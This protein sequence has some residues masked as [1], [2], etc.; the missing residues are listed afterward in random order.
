CRGR[1][2]VV[3]SFLK[4][5]TVAAVIAAVAAVAW[6]WQAERLEREDLATSLAYN[7]DLNRA[8]Q[9]RLRRDRGRQLVQSATEQATRG[10]TVN[11]ERLASAALDLGESPEARGLLMAASRVAAPRLL[12]TGPEQERCLWSGT[13]V[14]GRLLCMGKDAMHVMN[15]GGTGEVK[16]IVTEN[17]TAP[18]RHA[19]LSRDGAA[20]VTVADT[21]RLWEV[22]ALKETQT[23]EPPPGDSVERVYVSPKGRWIVASLATGTARGWKTGADTERKRSFPDG[24]R[25][26]SFLDGSTAVL[27]AGNSLFTWD[28]SRDRVRLFATVTN[29]RAVHVSR[30]GKTVA[31]VST[32]ED[33]STRI[34]ALDR[35]ASLRGEVKLPE[36]SIH[37]LAEVRN[38]GAVWFD[39][40]FVPHITA[41]GSRPEPFVDLGASP[42][43]MVAGGEPLKLWAWD[44]G[45]GFW[46]RPAPGQSGAQLSNRGVLLV[47]ATESSVDV[48]DRTT[49][50]RSDRLSTPAAAGDIRFSENDSFFSAV[51]DGKTRIWDAAAPGQRSVEFDRWPDSLRA[52]FVSDAEWLEL[53]PGRL[54]LVAAATG[55]ETVI[56]LPKDTRLTL[57]AALAPGRGVIAQ[58]GDSLVLVDREGAVKPLASVRGLK[59]STTKNSVA[60]VRE[61]NA[62]VSWSFGSPES[63]TAMAGAEASGT[64]LLAALA[65][66]GVARVRADGRLEV[67]S[68]DG[69]QRALTPNIFATAASLRVHERAD[70]LSIVDESGAVSMLDLKLTDADRGEIIGSVRQRL[71]QNK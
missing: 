11:A 54:R 40:Q 47:R 37:V 13:T 62:I 53:E 39:H 63:V 51:I 70:L 41:W 21:I 17:L 65:S 10:S 33:G 71:G 24:L 66:G 68:P 31:V 44:D 67:F 29:P 43:P 38:S 30:D 27:A 9:K 16:R 20:L 22:P 59:I 34:A 12:W 57:P 55:E 61:D 36:S 19:A 5:G 50:T 7:E 60:V 56:D 28:L 3:G 45:A 26:L 52:G 8:L 35:S 6:L 46:S 64:A 23:F 58:D 49:G 69:N 4:A 15:V 14:D 48:I 32:G 18:V 2:G 1:P 25:A 42:A